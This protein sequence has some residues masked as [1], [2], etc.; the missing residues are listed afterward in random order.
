M[1][2]NKYGVNPSR[3]RGQKDIVEFYKELDTRLGATETGLQI[4]NTAIENGNLIIRNGDII[5]ELADQSPVLRILHG[6]LPEIRMFPLGE[7]DTHRA[8]LFS[9]DDALG[10]SVALLVETHPGGD[11]DG[12]K[13]LLNRDFAVISH[14]P[15]GGLETNIFLNVDLVTPQVINFQCRWYDQQQSSSEQGL[16][17]GA[18]T[19]TSGFTTWT[20]TYF[21][22]FDTT[23]IPVFTVGVNGTTIQWGIENYSTSSFIIRFSTTAGNKFVTFWNF[24]L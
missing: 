18:F 9:F 20:H 10:Q 12:G 13:L 17:M 14:Q 4:G 24:R 1:T 3:L 11:L 21:T 2:A 15:I 23:T 16:Y 7:N 5:V 19:A 8:S 22:P 6:T